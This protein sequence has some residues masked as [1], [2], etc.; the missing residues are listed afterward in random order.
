MSYEQFAFTT[1]THR[2]SRLRPDPD[3]RCSI[4]MACTSAVIAYPHPGH[5]RRSGAT[6]VR[7]AR[8][9]GPKLPHVFRTEVAA[10]LSAERVCTG[11]RPATQNHDGSQKRPASM[12]HQVYE[13]GPKPAFPL[14]RGPLS[15]WWQ[16]KDSNLR[17]FRDG[18]TVP[19]LQACDQWKRP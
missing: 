6:T 8:W 5:T 16:V 12:P 7:P 18:F 15:T 2:T 14:V 13:K 11:H 9:L 3:H 4:A 10:V 17:S 1:L 19:R